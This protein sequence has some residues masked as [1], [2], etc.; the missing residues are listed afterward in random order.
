MMNQP[1]GAH[2]RTAGVIGLVSKSDRCGQRSA[3]DECLS[4][5]E[6]GGKAQTGLAP[7]FYKED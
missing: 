3:M 6:G 5:D 7:R 4:G 1:K 2:P